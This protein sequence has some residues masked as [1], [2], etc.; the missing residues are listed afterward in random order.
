MEFRGKAAAQ[1]TTAAEDF[2]GEKSGMGYGGEYS[3]EFGGEYG[4]EAGEKLVMARTDERFDLRFM[5]SLRPRCGSTFTHRL[6]QITY[7]ITSVRLRL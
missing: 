3:G 1:A 6:L 5:L 2:E 7:N 4:N